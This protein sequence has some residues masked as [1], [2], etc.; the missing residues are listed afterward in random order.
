MIELRWEIRQGAP[1]HS[2]QMVEVDGRRVTHRIERVL[3]Y[4]TWVVTYSPFMGANM[5]VSWD[6]GENTTQ[7]RWTEWQ[8]VP[9]STPTAEA[10]G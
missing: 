6:I 3:Q 1:Y 8:D 10:G 2:S 4:R 9:V 7:P 5:F